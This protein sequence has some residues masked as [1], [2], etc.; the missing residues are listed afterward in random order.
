[1]RRPQVKLSNAV[2]TAQVYAGAK[3]IH[4]AGFT[5]IYIGLEDWKKG[6]DYLT[7]IIFSFSD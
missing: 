2:V 3:W 6:I 4:V 1:M 5:T 7:L